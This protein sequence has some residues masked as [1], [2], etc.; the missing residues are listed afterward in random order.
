MIHKTVSVVIPCHPSHLKVL[1]E[2]LT[3]LEKQSVRPDEIIVMCSSEFPGINLQRGADASKGD[4]IVYQGADDVAH[5]QRIELIRA[6]FERHDGMCDHLM[7]YFKV[8][9]DSYWIERWASSE[10]EIE[11]AAKTAVHQTY[12]VMSGRQYHNGNIAVSRNVVSSI[13]YSGLRE[14]EDVEL[15]LRVAEKFPNSM[16]RVPIELIH[17]RQHLSTLHG[18]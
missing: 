2:C 4:I 18:A 3:S 8:S 13:K 1:H 17:Y 16:M 7:H 5:W 6:I 9:Q 10:Y 11:M 12:K 15:N 14:G